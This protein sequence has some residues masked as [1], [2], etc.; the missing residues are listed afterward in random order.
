M[1]DEPDPQL[2]APQPLDYGH[3]ARTRGVG[4]VTGQVL[5]GFL[6]WV[7]TLAATY[8]AGVTAGHLRVGDT[9]VWVAAALPLV[10][11]L[12]FGVYLRVRH[13][14]RGFLPGMLLG[15]GLTCLVPVGIVAVVCG[16]FR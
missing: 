9:F 16:A 6:A 14:W 4:P 8:A 10:G 12:A 13:G 11:A 2:A 1:P 15:F 7:C 3:V 5:L